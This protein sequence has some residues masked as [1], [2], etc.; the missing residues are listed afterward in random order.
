[1][2][3]YGLEQRCPTQLHHWAKIFV[4]ILKRAA[5][6]FSKLSK[7]LLNTFFPL[8]Q[9]ILP[10]FPKIFRFLKKKFSPTKFSR[11]LGNSKKGRTNLSIGPHAARRPRV[12]HPGL[13]YGL[14]FGLGLICRARVRC[15]L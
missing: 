11:Q 13:E 3:G 9:N 6:L 7:F 1:M 15:R 14:W 10:H 4:T 12:G 5:K 2:L 8:T